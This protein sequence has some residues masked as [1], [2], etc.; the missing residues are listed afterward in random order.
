VDYGYAIARTTYG[1][2]GVRVWLYRGMYGDEQAVAAQQ[3]PP[4]RR[5]G[6]RGRR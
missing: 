6:R 3:A 2:I 5:P 1:T 4:S